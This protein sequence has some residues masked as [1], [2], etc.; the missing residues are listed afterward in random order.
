MYRVELSE[1]AL[2]TF[3]KMDKQRENTLKINIGNNITNDTHINLLY[4]L[5]Y[6][7]LNFQFNFLGTEELEMYSK[8]NHETKLRYSSLNFSHDEIKPYE[9]IRIGDIN[10]AVVGLTDLYDLPEI[11]KLYYKNEL[12][13]LLYKLEKKVDCV[14]VVSDLSRAENIDI[15]KSFSGVNMLIESG[16]NINIEN[17]LKIS[18]NQYI[19]PVKSIAMVDIEYNENGVNVFDEYNRPIKL[20]K[21][22]LQNVYNLDIKYYEADKEMKKNVEWYKKNIQKEKDIIAGYNTQTFYAKDMLVGDKIEMLDKLGKKIKFFYNA[23]LTILPSTVLH[24]GLKQGL[25]TEREIDVVFS[26]DKI[27]VFYIGLEDL[28]KLVD[29]STKNKGSENYLYF[30]GFEKLVKQKKYKVVSLESID[31]Y[32]SDFLNDKYSIRKETLKDF[33]RGGLE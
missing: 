9:I 25:Y 21:F 27:L 10:V 6:K 20:E 2:K 29:E 22:V 19:L 13:K 12:Q 23:D 32:Y 31:K 11:E 5:Y 18:E 24:G 8:L 28:K 7:K 17:T 26:N 1:N 33:L 4:D 14:F 15:M 30:V 16:K 3:K